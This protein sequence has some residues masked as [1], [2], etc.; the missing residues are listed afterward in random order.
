MS[1]TEPPYQASAGQAPDAGDEYDGPD[2]SHDTSDVNV[3]AIIGFAVGM[4]VVTGVV[5][6]LMYGL[7]W[8]FSREAAQNDPAVSPLAP[9][10]VEMPRSTMD[11]PFFGQGQGVRLVTHEPS[12]LAKQRAMEQEV[13]DSYGWVDQKSGI[14]RIPI[15]EA[16]KLIL[17][18]GL[19][20]RA[21]GTDQT[22]GTRRAA[23]GESSGGRAITH[24]P[25][26]AGGAQEPPAAA[27]G[28][29]APKGHGQ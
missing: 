13:L 27:P 3:R 25:A 8:F 29:T 26:A 6:V 16:K 2:P 18:R 9:A 1:H 28:H 15:A 12:V 4:F 20:A 10:S 23:Y 7:F 22:L 14:A 24:R 21:D 17:Q 19:P 5:F 11:N